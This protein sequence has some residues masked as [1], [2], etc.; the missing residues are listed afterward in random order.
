MRSGSRSRQFKISRSKCISNRPHTAYQFF[1]DHR[2]VGAVRDA[3]Q[4]I[5]RLAAQ[6]LVGVLQAVDDDQLVVGRGRGVDADLR[7]WVEGGW[8]ETRFGKRGRR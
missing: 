1:D 6:R 2:H 8:K 7:G 3:I 5:E 4:Q